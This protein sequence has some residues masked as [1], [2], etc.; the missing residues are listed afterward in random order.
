MSIFSINTLIVSEAEKVG[1]QTLSGTPTDCRAI[2]AVL[3]ALEGR[4]YE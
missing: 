3:H 4:V 2:H 1:M